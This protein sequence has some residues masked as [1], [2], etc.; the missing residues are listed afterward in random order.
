MAKY[1]DDSGLSRFWNKIKSFLTGNYQSKLYA[2]SF[3][4]I[5]DGYVFYVVSSQ[6]LTG[7]ITGAQLLSM[8]YK[9]TIV[10]DGDNSSALLVVTSINHG[11]IYMTWCYDSSGNSISKFYDAN[12][13][14]DTIEKKAL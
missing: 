8:V 7:I 1:L 14:L 11:T 12:V 6:N 9:G 2:Y 10:Y 5:D 3:Y 4:D 13:E